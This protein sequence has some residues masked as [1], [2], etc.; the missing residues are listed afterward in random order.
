VGLELEV[1]KVSAVVVAALGHCVVRVSHGIG[2][3]LCVCL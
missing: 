2:F 1:A 3:L